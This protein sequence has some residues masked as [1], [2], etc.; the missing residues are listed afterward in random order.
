[1]S[2]VVEGKGLTMLDNSVVLHASEM[3]KPDTHR[4]SHAVHARPQSEW[5]AVSWPRDAQA[6]SAATAQQSAL[7]AAEPVQYRG[8]NAWNAD[9]APATTFRQPDFYT[10][11]YPGLV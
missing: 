4:R 9:S 10:G 11:A 2:S 3:Q 1:M 6:G 8:A 7:F 5:K